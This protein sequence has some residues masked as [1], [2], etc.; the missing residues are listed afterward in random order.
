MGWSMLTRDEQAAVDALPTTTFPC[1][2]KYCDGK[3]S[4]CTEPLVPLGAALAAIDGVRATRRAYRDAQLA[5]LLD[6]G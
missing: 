4:D 3:C 1:D 6:D 5:A 2:D